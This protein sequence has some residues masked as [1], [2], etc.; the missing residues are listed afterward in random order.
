MLKWLIFSVLTCATAL[1]G[2][3][4]SLSEAECLALKNNKNVLAMRELVAKA[5]SGRLVSLS[6]WLPQ[7]E[8]ISRGYTTEKVQV[9]TG[10][11]R[12]FL[13]QFNALQNIISTDDYYDMRISGLLVQQM[14]LLFDALLID[15]LL[16]VRV[17]YYQVVFDRMTIATAE[18]HVELFQSLAN[19][20]EADYRIGTA[21][22]LTAN[23]AKVAIANATNAYYQA[24]KA[25]KE[26][27]DRLATLLGFDAGEIELV[28]ASETIPVQEVPLLAEKMARV[29]GRAANI[30]PPL[31]SLEEMR[32]WECMA[33]RQRPSLRAEE[34]AVKIAQK[35]VAKERGHYVPQL[36]MAANIGG[37][38]TH[39]NELPSSNFFNQKMR[40]AVGFELSWNIF[41]GF[42]RERKICRA[43]HERKSRQ[44]E[45]R[46]A[47]QASY[48][49]VR[50]EI[51]EI[52][53]ATHSFATAEANVS[54]AAE[55]VELADSSLKIG[56]VTIFDYQIVV[57]SYI[58]AV[59]TRNQAQF[60]LIKGYYGLRHAAGVD[61]GCVG[62]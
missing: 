62:R 58:Q 57:D 35:Q 25:Y 15:I 26:D 1:F 53:E 43:M 20:A 39:M 23:Q 5:E 12:A 33:L 46:R 44:W 16:D 61:L 21:I 34:T 50:R 60:D 30:G 2:E 29:E 49:D 42:G 6:R 3:V 9:L 17:A 27:V 55:T 47:V 52:E 36:Q 54:L 32:G 45:Y 59:N 24:V 31:F 48:E 4:I 13:S 19:R 14:R 56:Y 22:L 38:P 8:L 7:V 37:N 28:V 18:E 10:A 40:W 51:F 41:D 11:K